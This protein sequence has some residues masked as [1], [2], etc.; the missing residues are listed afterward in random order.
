MTCAA[1]AMKLAREVKVM[2]NQLTPVVA[3]ASNTIQTARSTPGS[4]VSSATAI[5]TYTKAG[6]SR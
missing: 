3:A 1:T 5:S 2:P 4:K 6:I